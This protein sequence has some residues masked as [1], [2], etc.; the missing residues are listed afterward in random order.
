MET[1][2]LVSVVFFFWQWK[3]SVL[4]FIDKYYITPILKKLPL[5]N[6]VEPNLDGDHKVRLNRLATVFKCK[7]YY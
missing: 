6:N 5:Q 7:F 3:E 2:T 1:Y 4:M